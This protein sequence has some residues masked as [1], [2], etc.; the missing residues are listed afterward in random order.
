MLKELPKL[1]DLQQ[2]DIQIGQL[3]QRRN[4]LTQSRKIAHQMDELKRSLNRQERKL[5]EIE[6]QYAR[7]KIELQSLWEQQEAEEK[8]LETAELDFTEM[9]NL[10]ST[11]DR[12]ADQQERVVA[13]IRR[14][15]GERTHLKQDL[16]QKAQRLAELEARWAEVR[17]EEEL[18]ASLIEEEMAA[19]MAQRDKLV[20]DVSAPSLQRYERTREHCENLAIVQVENDICPGCRM[21]LTPSIVRQ[22]EEGREVQFCPNCRRILYWPGGRV[23][24]VAKPRLSSRRRS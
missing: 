24:I 6:S 20:R 13:D 8:R 9:S 12:L 22:L 21:V 7:K 18:E 14:I 19:L 10:R 17:A 4:G 11:L 5:E 3:Q 16:Q 1:Y 2:L 23:A 15:D